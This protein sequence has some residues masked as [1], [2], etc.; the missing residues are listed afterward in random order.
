MKNRMATRESLG[1]VST[2]LKGKK[3]TG[4]GADSARYRSS[5]RG[6]TAPN[7]TKSGNRGN[8]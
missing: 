1:K 6:N 3:N 7:S 4:K 8:I 5:A 2:F